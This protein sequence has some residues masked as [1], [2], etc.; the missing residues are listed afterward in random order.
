MPERRPE[1]AGDEAALSA[2]TMRTT[3]WVNYSQQMINNPPS[4]TAAGFAR[5][6]KLCHLFRHHRYPPHCLCCDTNVKHQQSVVNW[7]LPSL[8]PSWRD[9]YN[10]WQNYTISC[11]SIQYTFHEG[12]NYS[13]ND[14]GFLILLSQE[15]RQVS[16]LRSYRCHLVPSCKDCVLN[17]TQLNTIHLKVP[18]ASISAPAPCYGC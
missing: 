17:V 7:I 1:S 3:C 13:K 6:V 14:K 16:F 8:I 4:I 15:Y 2:T 5:L 11:Q 12:V 9:T 10:G 18:R